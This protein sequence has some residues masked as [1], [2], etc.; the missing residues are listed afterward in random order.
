MS[1][2]NELFNKLKEFLSEDEIKQGIEKGI[3]KLDIE[4]GDDKMPLTHVSGGLETGTGAI[5]ETTAGPA[6]WEMVKTTMQKAMDTM[7]K[8]SEGMS[9][10]MNK[11]DYKDDE[12]KDMEKAYDRMSSSADQMKNQMKM[13]KA[14][15]KMNKSE[16]A[17]EKQA[18]LDLIQK[19]FD[20]KLQQ[21][22]S[23]NETQIKAMAD[24]NAV[25][26]KSLSTMTEAF[27]QMKADFEKIS[28]ETPA[29]KSVNVKAFIEKGGVKGEDGKKIY[30]IGMHRGQ[31]LSELEKAK[32]DADDIMK[33]AIDESI[34]NFASAGVAPSADVAQYLYDKQN[35]KLMK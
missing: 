29:P 13:Y 19:S 31:I 16:D 23:Q 12:A 18:D 2:N 26:E 7:E 5:N 30:H 1:V 32:S 9:E 14:K 21:I 28:K 6:S 17:P 24:K 35:V 20:D 27:S 11:A 34:I 33:G 3:I 15:M 10:Y 8:A 4:K 25:L 22:T